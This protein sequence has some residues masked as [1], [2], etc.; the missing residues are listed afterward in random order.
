MEERKPDLIGTWF[1]NNQFSEFKMFI[2]KKKRKNN[3]FLILGEIID[4]YGIATFQG[5]LSRKF[6]KF[7]KLYD[8]T[9]LKNLQAKYLFYKGKW[10]SEYLARNKNYQFTGRDISKPG[11]FIGVFLKSDKNDK[12]SKKHID[13]LLNIHSNETFEIFVENQNLKQDLLDLKKY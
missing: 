5:T 4:K 7:I 1:Q 12:H 2:D 13:I 9:A 10:D 6:I 11:M 8:L 3:K